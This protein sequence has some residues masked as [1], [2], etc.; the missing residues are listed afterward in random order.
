VSVDANSS[1]EDP[2]TV[3][4]TIAN[5]GLVPLKDVR[6]SVALCNVRVGGIYVRGNG[7]CA[8]QEPPS[9][10]WRISWMVMDR[11]LTID[12]RDIW[13]ELGIPLSARV[14]PEG[15]HTG[16]RVQFRPWFF[17]I[18][19]DLHFPY[20]LKRSNDAHFYWAPSN[21]AFEDPTS[22]AHLCA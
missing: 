7:G 10:K 17:P 2:S 3:S 18:E 16:V 22:I 1:G 19:R 8:Y 21:F 15:S 11:K 9:C 12:F 6:I 13:D 14:M 20:A 4:F 5:T